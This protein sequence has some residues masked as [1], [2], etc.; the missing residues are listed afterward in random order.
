MTRLPVPVSD[1][2]TNRPAPDPQHTLRHEL[3][4]AADCDDHAVPFD[5]V[6]TREVPLLDTATRSPRSSDQQTSSHT[7]FSAAV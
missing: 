6:M 2:A 1:T 5:D 4:A 7:L 3:A